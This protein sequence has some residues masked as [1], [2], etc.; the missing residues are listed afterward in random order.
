MKVLLLNYEF[1]PAGGG[2]GFATL[3]IGR[4]LVE[5]GVEVH[6]LTSRI[7]SE[8]D[9]DMLDG[10]R[11][12]HECHP[13]AVYLHAGQSY[14]V[15]RLDTDA[16]RVK[17]EP[18]QVDYYTVVLGEKETEILERLESRTLGEHSV[19]FGK[20]KVTV[21]IRGYQKK[22]LVGGEPI[23]EHPLEAPPLIF[24]TT[25]L[26][27]ELPAAMRCALTA[28][29]LHFMGGIHATEHAMIGLFPLLAIAA[30]YFSLACW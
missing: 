20:L 6:V 21:R 30:W 16:R 3:N 13:D 11:V 2:A 29:G 23:S 10:M 19:G 8:T 25:G 14:R 28:E 18:V 27:I 7:E 17:V 12:F 15:A 24:E 5:L 1:P 4:Q 22:R 9:G 26:W